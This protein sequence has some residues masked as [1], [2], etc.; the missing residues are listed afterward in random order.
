MHESPT[1]AWGY[2]LDIYP[3]TYPFDD[4]TKSR[5][6]INYPLHFRN[7]NIMITLNF[8][9]KVLFSTDV[10]MC[11]KSVLVQDI[12][13]MN[14]YYQ[15]F[16]QYSHYSVLHEVSEMSTIFRQQASKEFPQ[17]RYMPEFTM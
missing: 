16:S 10:H 13:L 17:L 4:N 6:T 14:V 3:N 12:Y 11:M 8:I 9:I 15:Y 2:D 5:S 1:D 7:G